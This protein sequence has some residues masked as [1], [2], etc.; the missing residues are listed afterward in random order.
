MM[1][2]RAVPWM[3]VRYLAL[4]DCAIDETMR[5]FNTHSYIVLPIVHHCMVEH[6]PQI[7]K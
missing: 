3:C 5:V 2:P 1:D 7:S 6:Y 4:N